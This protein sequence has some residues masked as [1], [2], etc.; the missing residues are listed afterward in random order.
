MMAQERDENEAR[1]LAYEIERHAERHKHS[2]DEREYL[3]HDLEL[4]GQ[5]ARELQ[6][7]IARLI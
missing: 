1:R 3:I 6:A 5:M 2:T 4:I 7:V